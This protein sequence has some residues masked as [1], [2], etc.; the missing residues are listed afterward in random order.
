MTVHNPGAGVSGGTYR[1]DIETY[2]LGLVLAL[3]LT[4][5]PFALVYWHVLAPFWLGIAIGAF[6]VVQ[7]V[8][9]F[10]C[11]LHV[12]WTR[13]NF[14][15]LLVVSFTILILVM[16]VGGTVWILGNLHARMM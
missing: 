8:V 16:M 2:L 15:T 13:E 14:D 4:A 6:G 9:H 10:R 3:T 7:A 11:F 12:N 1:K 5:V